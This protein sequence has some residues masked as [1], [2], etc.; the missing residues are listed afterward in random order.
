MLIPGLWQC[1]RLSTAKASFHYWP[2]RP[3]PFFLPSTS[4]CMLLIFHF[5]LPCLPL[6]EIRYWQGREKKNQFKPFSISTLH[7]PVY[8]I[9]QLENNVYNL[10]HTTQPLQFIGAMCTPRIQPERWKF[11][12]LAEN[13]FN[14]TALHQSDLISDNHPELNQSR[15]GQLVYKILVEIV[16]AKRVMVS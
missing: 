15:V 12:S 10:Y 1:F 9:T 14:S 3:T 4:L 16:R 7:A 5:F 8:R 13:S 2:V 11:L 6:P